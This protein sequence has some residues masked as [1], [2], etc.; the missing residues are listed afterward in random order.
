MNWTN[1]AAYINHFIQPGNGNLNPLQ[2][3][4]AFV[5]CAPKGVAIANC[6][7]SFTVTPARSGTQML[8]VWLL[9]YNNAAL[10]LT[11]TQVDGK[12]YSVA[13][14][15]N[16]G[17]AYYEKVIDIQLN[18]PGAN[19][20]VA[21]SLKQTG[22]PGTSDGVFG[23]K[24][25]ALGGATN[26]GVDPAGIDPIYNGGPRRV[27][28]RSHVSNRPACSHPGREQENHSLQRSGISLRV[29]EDRL[30]DR[31]QQRIRRDGHHPAAR[32]CRERKFHASRIAA[33]TDG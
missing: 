10:T 19:S 8:H 11:T 28:R 29:R 32:L 14:P 25:V 22:Y 2:A 13:L 4:A 1:S 31:D 21:V 30:A 17:G 12:T 15:A 5:S 20:P 27:G 16:T 18:T 23:I 33:K 24:A 26:G 6:G 9:G 3:S 7:E